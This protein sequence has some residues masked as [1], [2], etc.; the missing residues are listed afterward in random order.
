LRR[1]DQADVATDVTVKY[2]VVGEPWQAVLLRSPKAIAESRIVQADVRYAWQADGRCLGA[3]FFDVEAA[4]AIDCPLELPAGFQLLQLSI[5]GLPVDAVR[6][7]A[8]TWAVPLAS[9][10]SVSHVEMLF[11]AESAIPHAPAGWPRRCM[12]RAPKLGDLPLD[13]IVWTIAAPGSLQASVAAGGQTSPPPSADTSKLNDIA[14][15]WQR[16]VEQGETT[17]SCA[18]SG[19]VEAIAVDYRP[20]EAQSWLPRLTGCAALL[21]VLGVAALLVRWG[22]V[23]TWFARW[24]YLFGVG[25]GLAW[26]LWLAPSAIGLLIVLAV[27]LGQLLPFLRRIH[28]APS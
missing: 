14:A 1:S 7:D 17:V 24:P 2:E 26:W 23:S 11:F 15:Q 20:M 3:A 28:H 21:V 4:G 5:D 6:G 13:R 27:L 25:I 16:F 12:F 22:L 8:G 19:S 10:P 9:Q 18:T